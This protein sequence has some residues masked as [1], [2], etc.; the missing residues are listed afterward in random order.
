MSFVGTLAKMA[1]GVAIAKGVGAVM[2]QG[3]AA[4]AGAPRK[5]ATGGMFGNATTAQATNASATGGLEDM[6][7]SVL[8]GSSG[9]AAGGAAGGLGGLLEQ[10][11]GGSAQGGLQQGGIGDLLGKLTGQAGTAAGGGTG[12]LA[13]ALGGLIGGGAAAGAATGAAASNNKSFGEVLNASL[14]NGGEPNE[15][16]APHHEAAAALMLRAMIQAAKSDGAIDE[17]EKSKLTQ[18]LTD[19]AQS[20]IA[21]VKALI[22]APVDVKA[23]ARDVPKG[24]EAQVYTMSVM[25]INLD[26][27]AEANYLNELA[28]AMSLDE[29]QINGIHAK[30]GVA[31]LYS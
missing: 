24:L 11:A 17:A 10:L 22:A 29:Q 4:A 5:T 9:A 6:M 21:F 16:P 23:L 7:K 2:N 28:K 3:G 27:Q 19:A 26:N 8:G 20:E 30:L 14:Q 31:A 25:A 15:P 1:I 18:S 12:A 13:D